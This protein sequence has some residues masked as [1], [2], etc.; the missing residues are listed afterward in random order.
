[1]HN[2]QRIKHTLQQLLQHNPTV[3]SYYVPHLWTAANPAGSAVVAVNPFRFYLEII[4]S[5]ERASGSIPKRNDGGEWS[6]EAVIYNML[7]RTTCAFD[8]NQNGKLDLPTNSDGFREV[9]T[10]LKAIALLPYIQRLGANTVHLLPITAIG[11]DGNKGSL[12][13]PYA[14]KNPYKLDETLS[15]PL[16]GL[17]SEVEFAAFV[18][19]AH[20]LGI[21]VVV[22]FVFRTASKDADWILEHP[23][24][25]Y[26]IRAD[27]PDRHSGSKDESKYGTPLFTPDELRQI[28]AAVEQQR[29]DALLPPHRMYREMFTE[30]PKPANIRNEN[31]RF[32]GYL[33][34]GTRV[35]IPG[36]FAD[37]PP[38]DVQP[39]WGDVTYLKLHHHPDFNYMAYNTVRMYDVRLDRPEYANHDLWEKIIGIIPYFQKT[40]GIDGV[41]IDMGHSLPMELKHRMIQTARAN[42]PDFAFWDENFAVTQRSREEGYNAVIGYCWTDQ[43]HLHKFRNLLKRFEREG[44]PLPFFATPE[45]HNTPRAAARHGGILYSKAAWFIDNFMPAIPFIH[46]G[47]ELGETYPINTG[48]DFSPEEQRSFPSERLPLFSE[49]AYDWQRKDEITKSIATIS[50]LRR[51][52]VYLITNQDPSSF[53]LLDAGNDAIIAFLRTDRKSNLLVIANYDLF[54]WQSGMVPVKVPSFVLKDFLSGKVME[55]KESKLSLPPGEC[56]LFMP[57]S[58]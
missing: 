21:R 37:W 32:T 36:A 35:R 49:F 15:E 54:N 45:S 25:F 6:R 26:W 50:A 22:E 2:L 53:R 28:T 43:H 5:I 10:F 30:P 46:S 38:D 16:L 40:F 8:H 48:L 42:D 23:E 7:V 3:A 41:M 18:E 57:G 12:G 47:F 56:V 19:A 55:I 31:G 4:E 52:Y 11:H 24:W 29:F 20:R 13:S 58:G 34:D 27:I 17:G 39:P 1:M 44:F 33:E 14:I 51:E 9:G